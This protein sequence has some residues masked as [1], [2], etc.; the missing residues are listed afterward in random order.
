M[1]TDEKL[2]K[3]AVV[4]DDFQAH[5]IRA[6]LESAGIEAFVMGDELMASLPASGLPRVEVYVKAD[7]VE[8]ARTILAE[9]EPL[10]EYSEDEE[11]SE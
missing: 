7:D 4:M 10:E 9:Q 2:V 11:N 8:T 3:V 5:A 6:Q 1:E